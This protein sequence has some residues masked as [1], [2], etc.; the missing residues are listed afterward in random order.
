MTRIRKRKKTEKMLNKIL[1]REEP[2][3][4]MTLKIKRKTI[5]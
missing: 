2:T 5:R 3:K 4:R 1:K